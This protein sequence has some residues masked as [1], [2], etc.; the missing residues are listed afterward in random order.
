MAVGFAAPA[1]PR[2]LVEAEQQ[3]EGKAAKLGK[4]NRI[5]SIWLKFPCVIHSSR[6]VGVKRRTCPCCPCPIA[7]C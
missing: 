7:V 6:T 1:E 2:Q 5:A 4:R 3:A